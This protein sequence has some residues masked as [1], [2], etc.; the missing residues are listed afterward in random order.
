MLIM[1]TAVA[2]GRNNRKSAQ[3]STLA[4]KD[5]ADKSKSYQLRVVLIRHGIAE[6]R[7]TDGRR[8]K[9]DAQRELT[10]GGR[11]KMRRAAKG[12]VRLVPKLDAMATSTLVRAIETGEIIAD[13][14]E[15][16]PRPVR[17][18][19]LSPRKPSGPAMEWLREQAVRT[20]G[21][22]VAIVG[23]EPHLGE[24]VSW[25]LTGLHDSFITLKKGSACV[26]EFAHEVKPA[27][28]KLVWVMKASQLRRVGRN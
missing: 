7:R 20:S 8:R 13:R 10:R 24:F 22:T 26:I 1:N 25:A 4:E 2:A 9:P 6:Q 23:H 19:G 21:G 17:L 27:R 11:R 28:A 5:E 12:L 18:A 15:S 3:E 16:P 14:Y